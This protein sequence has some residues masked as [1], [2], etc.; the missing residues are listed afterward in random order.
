MTLGE[1]L[2]KRLKAVD[3]FFVL[4]GAVFYEAFGAFVGYPFVHYIAVLFEFV[5]RYGVAAGVGDSGNVDADVCSCSHSFFE[6]RCNSVV[7]GMIGYYCFS[8]TVKADDLGWPVEGDEHDDY[9]T[10]LADVGYCF[11]TAAREVL[12]SDSVGAEDAEGVE[13]FW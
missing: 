12:I 7:F 10:I 2:V 13:A 1:E 6:I 8:R 9:A 11:S 4:E 5:E 3:A